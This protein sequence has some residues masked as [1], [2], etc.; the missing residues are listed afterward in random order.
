MKRS[1]EGFSGLEDAESDREELAHH[2]TEEERCGRARDLD[3]VLEGL[4]GAG[5]CVVLVGFA[6]QAAG[7]ASAPL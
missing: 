6:P 4:A 1:S 5:E 3:A 7:G 2:G